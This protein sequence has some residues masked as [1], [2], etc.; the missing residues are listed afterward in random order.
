LFLSPKPQALDNNLEGYRTMNKEIDDQQQL[1]RK[2]VSC[3]PN[4][5]ATPIQILSTVMSIIIIQSFCMPS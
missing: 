2:V 1:S 5:I 4:I 3:P